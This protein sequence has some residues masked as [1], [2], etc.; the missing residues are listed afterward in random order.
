MPSIDSMVTEITKQCIEVVSEQVINRLIDHL[1]FSGLFLNNS[2]LFITSDDLRSSRFDDDSNNI[3]AQNNRCDVKIVPGYNTFETKFDIV[4]GKVLDAAMQADRWTTGEYPVFSDPRSQAYVVEVALPSMIEL[5]FQIRL[6]SI[7][8]SDAFNLALFSRALVNGGIT[9]YNDIQFSYGFP[10]KLLLLLHTIYKMQ[11][12][13]ASEMT[14][15]EYLTIGSNNAISA[16]VN[17]SR[18]SGDVELVI[19]KTNS[20]VIGRLEYDGDKH[21][22]EDF[23]K[24]SNR[25]VID[26]SYFIQYSRPVFLR[27]SYPIMVYNK[28]IDKPLIAKHPANMS[29]GEGPQFFQDK[30]LNR[31]FLQQNNARIDLGASYP[32]I[33]Y[34]F[35]DDWQRSITMYKD[36]NQKYQPIFIGLM[37][38]TINPDNTLTLSVDLDNEVFPLL[39]DKAVDE[40]KYAIAAFEFDED[41]YS[42]RQ[43]IF[44]RL[45]IFDIEVFSNDTII[46]FRRLSLDANYVLTISGIKDITKLYRLVISQIKDIRILNRTYIYYILEHPDYYK[47]F[48]ACH[49]T[50]LVENKF[51]RIVTDRMTNVMEAEAQFRRIQDAH[52]TDVPC[53]AIIVHNYI[54]EVIKNR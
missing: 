47:D 7:E 29:I 15:K 48:I 16:L 51:V 20:K 3:R 1:G 18:P 32:L 14:F 2:N 43:D 52:W 33:R 46:D 27:T 31:Y 42:T 40:I 12:D 41:A 30:S 9:D 50:Y 28:L 4:S 34:P 25:Y 37:S 45:G 23:N 13:V 17:R 6:K 53:R 35:Y 38:V 10:D 19:Q 24:V 5:Q 26:F 11:D 22:T 36:V 8:L 44:R 49:M 39:N 21:E 54:I